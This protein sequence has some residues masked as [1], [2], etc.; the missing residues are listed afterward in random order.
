ML[1]GGRFSGV[2]VAFEYVRINARCEKV[3]LAG[4]YLAV[5]GLIERVKLIEWKSKEDLHWL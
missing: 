4:R 5:N 2:H 1:A 3:W